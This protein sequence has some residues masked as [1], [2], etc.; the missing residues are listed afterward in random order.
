MNRLKTGLNKRNEGT[1]DN[2]Q[3]FSSPSVSPF[4]LFNPVVLPYRFS[5]RILCT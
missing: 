5:V 3:Q 4:L 1:E 2:Q